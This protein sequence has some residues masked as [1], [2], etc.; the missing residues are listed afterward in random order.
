M[1]D[2]T[3]GSVEGT[4]DS[5]RFTVRSG[6]SEGFSASGQSIGSVQSEERVCQKL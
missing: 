3:M 6:G 2:G 4:I 5:R 1:G